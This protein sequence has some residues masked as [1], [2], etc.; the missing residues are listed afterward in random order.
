MGKLAESFESYNKTDPALLSISE[1]LVAYQTTLNGHFQQVKDH[2]VGPLKQFLRE[3][4]GQAEE[5]G[6]RANHDL[7]AYFKYLDSYLTISKKER[8][9]KLEEKETRLK[10]AHWQAVLSD[11]QL[12]RS[13][14]LVE[15]KMLIDISATVRFIHRLS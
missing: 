6:H 8:G 14:S 3:D 11:F 9:P 10:A 7:D 12:E 1:I 5:D 13:L 15:R 2:I 4:I